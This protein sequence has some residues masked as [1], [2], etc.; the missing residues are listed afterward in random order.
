MTSRKRDAPVVTMH[1]RSAN[2]LRENTDSRRSLDSSEKNRLNSEN[3]TTPMF[4]AADHAQRADRHHQP[5]KDE[6][7]EDPAGQDR[8][9]GRPGSAFHQ[10]LDRLAVPEPDGLDRHGGE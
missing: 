1:A 5:D 8:L 2:V 10:P 3:T 9:A 7:A 4:R 6:P